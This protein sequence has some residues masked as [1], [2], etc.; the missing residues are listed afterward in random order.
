VKKSKVLESEG[1]ENVSKAKTTAEGKRLA[2]DESR[3]KNWKR[4]GTYLPARQWATVREDYSEGGNSWQSFDYT[5]SRSRVYR[6]GED[7]LLGWCDRQCRVAVAP[8]L[9]NQQDDHLKER[10]FGL[11][12]PEGNHGEDVKEVYYY[13]DATPTHSYCRARYRYPHSAFPYSELRDVTDDLGREHDEYEITDTDVFDDAAFFDLDVEYA[14]KDPDTTLI[15]YTV[16]N[17]GHRAAPLCLLGQI[18]YRNTWKWGRE[19][20]DYGPKP[21]M[22]DLGHQSLGLQHH[23]LGRLVFAWREPTEEILFTENETDRSGL[24]G[25][26][27]ETP[28]V[29]NA[30]HRYVVNGQEAAVNPGRQGTKAAALYRITL[31]PGQTRSFDFILSGGKELARAPFA[32]FDQTMKK[33]LA[34]ADQFYAALNPGLNAEDTAIWRQAYAGLVWSK[35][36]Y[37]YAVQPW[38]EGD[39]TQPPPPKPKSRGRNLNWAG[40]LY[41]RDIILMP[42]TWEYPWYAAWD[43]AFHA[44]PMSYLDPHFAKDQLLL[45]L[46]EWYM[47]PNGQLPAYEFNF[48]DVNPPVHAW[49]C[50]RVY[51]ATGG[52][53]RAFL[54]RAFHKLLLNFTWWVNR[55]DSD[56]DNVFTGGFLGLD[57]IG[58][59]DR[60]RFPKSIG[61]LKQ[62][63]A[64]A[65]MGFFGL[66]MLQMAFEL[67]DDNEAYQ[68]IASKF[69]EHFVAISNSAN[70]DCGNGLWHAK[71]R[72]YYDFVVPHGRPHIPMR[73]RSLVGLLPLIAV[74]ILDRDQLDRMPG[75][76]NRMDWFLREDAS[77]GQHFQ[78][79]P[80][81]KKLLLSLAPES[82]FRSLVERMLDEDEFLSPFG[83]RSLSRFHERHPFHIEY[84][85][86]SFGVSYEPGES[87][88]GMF[89]GNSNWRG[90]IWF[91]IN[92]LLIDALKRY[93]AFYG[94][95]FKVELPTRSGNWVTLLEAARDLENRLV[96]LFRADPDGQIPSV[97][98]VSVKEP[99]HLWTEGRL[100][101]EYFH[102]ESGKG[103]GACHQTGWTA[104]VVRCLEDLAEKAT[105]AACKTSL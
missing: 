52:T 95:D 98:N 6:W 34:E 25:A 84:E 85:G 59:F 22:E 40:N 81:G 69:F 82:R 78:H 4:W 91:P 47:H 3:A 101:H 42:D 90:P 96:S 56:G 39:P 55:T 60:S 67:A 44:Y 41:N 83:I 48:S 93:Y 10:L 23:E 79:S 88:S 35:Q 102:A 104:L 37:F 89:G 65:W 64:T 73:V 63:D 71:D 86:Q 36:F 61:E 32:D 103:L 43:L 58:A 92:Y 99:R 15:R 24:Y 80:D 19:G 94:D 20:E 7:G 18:W 16:T 100:Y 1:V 54:E 26:P 76:R 77:L 97:P 70:S 87:R 11:T 45:M 75:F 27:N 68:D 33:R 51:R 30:F 49:A 21:E 38:L 72:F 13:L 17:R 57:N 74:E 50:L 105:V 62:A 53:D 8:A 28:W 2:E 31:E 66:R 29:K 9:W 46:R 5:T 12:G 14:K